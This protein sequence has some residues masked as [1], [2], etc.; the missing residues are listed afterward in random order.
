MSIPTSANLWN[1][2]LKITGVAE[3]GDCPDTRCFAKEWSDNGCVF[4]SA[5]LLVLKTPY[6][7]AGVSY[8]GGRLFFVGLLW[9][10]F[11]SSALFK[12]P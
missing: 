7:F 5:F 12:F 10:P 11:C 2:P 4:A 3:Q 1:F 6:G 9:V 8:A